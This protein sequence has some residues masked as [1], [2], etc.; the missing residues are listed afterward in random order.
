M[1]EKFV[2]RLM[3]TDDRLLAWTELA[4]E[5]RPQG[6]RR[7]CPFWPTTPT[8][9]AI[10][11]S[12]IA[13]KVVIHWCELDLAR[14]MDLEPIAVLEGQVFDF[15]WIGPVW[16]VPAM[17]KE[18][19]LPDLGPVWLQIENAVIKL[20]ATTVKGPTVIAP[21]TGSLVGRSQ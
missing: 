7:S 13:S 21:P 20:P 14:V 1:T 10:E 17:D 16:L 18:I 19:A 5:S 2:I 3:D 6:G 12:G 15:T 11:T 8:Q 9:F 4:C